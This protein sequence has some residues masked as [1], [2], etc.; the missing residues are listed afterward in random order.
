MP[1]YYNGIVVQKHNDKFAN[2]LLS[3]LKAVHEE[4]AYDKIMAKWGIS[5][6]SLKEPGIN[7]ATKKPLVEPK[8]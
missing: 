2:A 3:A 4:G 5:L 7:L 6:L 1:K 8:P